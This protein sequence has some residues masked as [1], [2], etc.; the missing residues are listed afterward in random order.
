MAIVLAE[1]G[2]RA[3]FALGEQR[4][5]QCRSVAGVARRRLIANQALGRR[6]KER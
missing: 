4:P 3:G 1:L 6:V 5:L 2:R